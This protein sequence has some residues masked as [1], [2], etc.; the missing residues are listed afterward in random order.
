M[1][2]VP[3]GS[4]D[5]NSLLSGHSHFREGMDSSPRLGPTPQSPQPPTMYAVAV[6]PNNRIKS[7]LV[8]IVSIIYLLFFFVLY[9]K[10]CHVIVRRFWKE[11]K[12]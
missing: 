12:T 11:K 4:R 3:T 5:P 2:F 10:I 6:L 8:P 7:V 1:Y 9:G